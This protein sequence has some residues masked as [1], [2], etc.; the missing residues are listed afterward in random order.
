MA[1]FEPSE[2]AAVGTE[3][4]RRIKIASRLEH[5]WRVRS[6]ERNF[7]KRVDR[8]GSGGGV[9]LADPNHP[10]A[11]RVHH[12]VGIAQ[13]SRPS[14]VRGD[15]NGRPSRLLAIKALVRVVAKINDT[16]ADEVRPAAIFM[17]PGPH[18]ECRFAA[19]IGGVTFT[20]LPL[21]ARRTITDRPFS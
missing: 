13:S 12:A 19:A 5:P 2:L 1:P 11:P 21:A 17:D 4:R 14:R 16:V 3:T 7:D 18:V 15:C 10:P 8:L 9:V 6:V 20:E